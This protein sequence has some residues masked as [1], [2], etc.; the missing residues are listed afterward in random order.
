MFAYYLNLLF[1]YTG[2]YQV[3]EVFSEKVVQVL[4]FFVKKQKTR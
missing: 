1:K 2:C 4:T 3:Y